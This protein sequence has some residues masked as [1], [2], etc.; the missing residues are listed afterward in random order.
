VSNIPNVLFNELLKEI[1]SPLMRERGYTRRRNTFYL[2]Y[3]GNYG[4]INFQKSVSNNSETLRF[5][6]NLGVASARLLDF[7]A[8]KHQGLDLL[9]DDCHW[10]SRIGFFLSP[11]HDKWWTINAGTSLAEVGREING[12]LIEIA[13]P[14]VEKHLSDTALRDLWLSGNSPGLTSFQRLV[15]L[16]LL[17]KT[18]G[19]RD[20]LEDT[21]NQ[22]KLNSEND[23]SNIGATYYLDQLKKVH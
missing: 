21:I 10:S 22:I 18:I 15:Y 1:V 5:T 16:S 6:I 8:T 3:A 11:P 20:L 4:L 9:I 12:C 2:P 19:P 17:L 23:P 14:E 7:L 13:V